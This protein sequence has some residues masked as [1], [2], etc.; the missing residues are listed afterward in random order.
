MNKDLESYSIQVLRE[1][2]PDGVSIMDSGG[3]D[4]A[5]LVHIAKKAGIPFK[6]VHNLTT[7]DAPE[8]VY[9]VRDKFRKLNEQGI[10]AEIVKPAETMWQLIE[11]KCTPPTR[12]I[13]YCCAVLKEQYGIGEKIATGVRRSESIK[14]KNNQGVVTIMN[15]GKEL[16][17]KVDNINFRLTNSGGVVL[18]NLDN[19]ETRDTYE[20][21]Y[22]TRKAIV[23]P[24]IDWTDEDIWQYIRDEKIEINPLYE[25]GWDRVGC[26]GCPMAGKHRYEEF[27][28]Y[29]KYEAAYKKA[30]EK[31]LIHRKEKGLK[32][33]SYWTNADAVFRWWMEDKTDP[34]QITI[35]QYM[36]ELNIRED[37]GF[38]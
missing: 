36:Q 28:K 9:Y 25:C 32:N 21:C 13:R 16:K 4:S 23:N 26:I 29:P 35:E 37:V 19:D 34:N 27:A 15:P 12:L 20:Y 1:L 14:R 30:F 11:R 24:L 5:V 18:L 33:L 10:H 3:K 8:T 2:C 22:R 31:M 6:V 38:N 17:N 7:V